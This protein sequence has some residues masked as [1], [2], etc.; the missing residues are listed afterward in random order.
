[1]GHGHDIDSTNGQ[2]LS[3]HHQFLGLWSVRNVMSGWYRRRVPLSTRSGPSTRL[4]LR[5]V[6]SAIRSP[7]SAKRWAAHVR[8]NP[9]LYRQ[10]CLNMARNSYGHLFRITTFGESHGPALGVVTDGCPSG[11]ALAES[12]LSAELARRRPVRARSQPVARKPINQLI[13]I[14][15]VAM[16]AS[17]ASSTASTTS[18]TALPKQH[19]F[20]HCTPRV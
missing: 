5:P 20:G 13:L 2:G 14:S 12:D 8:R 15:S 7:L 11:I 4:L 6:A 3:G 16:R 9:S 18:W 10:L 19:A 1:V 17:D